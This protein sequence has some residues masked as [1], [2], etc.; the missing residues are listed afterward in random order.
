MHAGCP[1][2]PD[3][4]AARRT[5]ARITL[6]GTPAADRRAQ[7]TT[8]C[9]VVRTSF[10][11]LTLR[12]RIP[13]RAPAPAALVAGASG[14]RRNGRGLCP[15]RWANG[16]PGVPGRHPTWL[17]LRP[18][19]A[20]SGRR[21]RGTGCAAGS[22]PRWWP[23]G[24][25]PRALGGLIVALAVRT[26]HGGVV[27]AS[28]PFDAEP[29]RP[30]HEPIGPACWCRQLDRPL[31]QRRPAGRRVA[32]RSEPLG[33]VASRCE[34]SCAAE[35]PLTRGPKRDTRGGRTLA[36]LGSAQARSQRTPRGRSSRL[37]PRVRCRR[38]ADKERTVLR[39]RRRARPLP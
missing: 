23:A 26:A 27:P 22:R 17:P 4:T 1:Q 35:R 36:L 6:C 31:P 14:D 28:G 15:P 8:R 33:G 10:I 2:L 11:G 30:R 3:R 29:P 21:R 39:R 13:E 37:G 9:C 24:R 38:A 34:R 20:N 32:D 18:T 25:E 19:E 16:H 12:V 5:A 7:Y